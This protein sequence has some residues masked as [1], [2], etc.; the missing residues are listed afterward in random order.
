MKES[1]REMIRE[2]IK[3]LPLETCELKTDP[4]TGIRGWHAPEGKIFCINGRFEI[5]ADKSK[6]NFFSY[7]PVPSLARYIADNRK[8]YN[9]FLQETNGDGKEALMLLIDD[10]NDE[11]NLPDDGPPTAFKGKWLNL[12]IGK[13]VSLIV[14]MEIDPYIEDMFIQVIDNLE[15]DN[16]NQ[17]SWA[18][19]TEGSKTHQFV[20]WQQFYAKGDL[21]YCDIVLVD[22][23]EPEKKLFIPESKPMTIGTPLWSDIANT[24]EIAKGDIKF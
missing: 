19:R 4:V 5:S 13:S 17:K 8:D 2:I 9:I 20:E 14:R 21:G 11:L 7:R 6:G 22:Y 3:T 1:P 12:D 15:P 10:L 23:E 16:P 18:W 24:R